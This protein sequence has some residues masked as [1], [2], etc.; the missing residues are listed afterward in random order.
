[1]GAWFCILFCFILQAV[2]YEYRKKENNIYGS[3]TYEIFLKIIGVA[4]SSFF[5]GSEFILK[6]HNFVSWQNPLH[7]LE[8]LLNLFN[9]LLFSQVF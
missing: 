6:E 4:V 9:Y 2:V 8:L 1:M 7:G 3:K 5:S